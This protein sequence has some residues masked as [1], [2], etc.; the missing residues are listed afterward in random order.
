[1]KKSILF[2]CVASLFGITG[3]AA[4]L[5]FQ[6]GSFELPAPGA[7]VGTAT[8]I[9]GSE[10]LF[11]VADWTLAA[12]AVSWVGTGW[13]A[14]AGTSSIGLS[15]YL[16]PGSLSQ[17]FD[18]VAGTMY[19]VIFAMAGNPNPAAAAVDPI[20]DLRV[21]AAGLSEDFTFNVSGKD[22]T[23]MGWTD[24]SFPFLA[25][26]DLTTL[27][28]ASLENNAFGPAI[29]NVRINLANGGSAPVPEPATL[30]LLGA[31]LSGLAL[32]GRKKLAN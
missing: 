21:S 24:Y 10:E 13:Q 6:N 27:I 19:E 17:T 23:N 7:G 2:F 12:G 14:A 4:A 8:Y 15:F 29:D 26:S 22:T 5:P 16:T 20:K 32:F 18:T 11:P 31:G 9:F 3:I 1:V 28:F 30:L 25:T